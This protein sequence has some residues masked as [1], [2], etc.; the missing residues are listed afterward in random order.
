MGL[1]DEALGFLRSVFGRERAER[2]KAESPSAEAEKHLPSSIFSVW[3][4]EDIGGLLS[5][6]Q[7]LMDRYADYEQMDEYPDINCITG[8]TTVYVVERSVLRP[9]S[10]HEL[11]ADVGSHDILAFDVKKN[12][13]VAV[14]AEHPRITGEK[15]PVI[16]IQFSNGELIKCTKDHKIL[17]HTK[18]YVDASTLVCGDEVV[19]CPSGFEPKSMGTLLHP[20]P[21]R[22]SVVEGPTD[23]GLA[24]V[25]DITTKTHNFVAN[26]VVVHNSANHYFTNDAT[27]PDIDTGRTVWLHAANDSIKAL[28]DNLLD[29]RLKI[30]D[31]VWSMAY[32]L[33]KM[34]N[35]YEEV[36]I[37]ENGV[38]GLNFLPVPTMRRVE[39]AN[40]SLIGYVQDVT[41]KFTQDSADLRGMLAGQNKIPD[42]VA[43]FE[44]FQVL[45]MR[46]RGTAR[47]CPY[48]YS[49]S[50]G[51]RWIWKRLVLLEDAMLIYKLTRAPARYAFYVDVTDVPSDRVESFLRKAKRDLKKTKLVN[52]RTQRL[53]MRYNPIAND[54][55]FFIAVR[56]GRELARV[57]VLQGPDYQ[58]TDDVEYFQRKLH[59]V[60]KVPR[61]YLG[62]EDAIP[63]RTILSNEDVRAARVTMAVQRELRNNIKRLVQIDLAARGIDPFRQD[64]QVLMTVPSGIYELAQMEIKNARADFAS[65]I[66]PFVSM[67]YI[68][69]KVFKLSDDEIEMIDKQLEKEQQQQAEQGGQPGAVGAGGP[70]PGQLPDMSDALSGKG[71]PPDIEIGPPPGQMGR[72]NN[73]A[74]WKKYDYARRLEE[75]RDQ[76]TRRN[77]SQISDQLATISQQNRDFSHRLSRQQSFMEEFKATAMSRLKNGRLLVAPSGRRNGR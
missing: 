54:E 23:M 34:G 6:S 65:R 28:G 14:E 29:R 33:V 70:A 24:D 3:G 26:G 76:L 64:F 11:A 63:N 66:Q 74:E 4:R 2:D 18:G 59:G 5:V 69:E 20:T 17:H 37:T 39:A 47:R 48:G 31:E 25:Y 55:D 19:S 71:P 27:Q 51:A 30:E 9:V 73:S 42:H 13:L 21:S 68:K 35:D 56:E 57:E 36:L 58:A 16:G 60:L 40:G 50:D 45:H 52:P 62:Q 53:D 7:N 1:R 38:V 12:S 72:P 15:A 61:N 46:L 8:D 22:L 10:V 41:G 44:D 32:Q 77:L 67:R 49:I 43:L 75:K